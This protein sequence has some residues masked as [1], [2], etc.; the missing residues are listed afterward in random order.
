M[1]SRMHR[2]S[3]CSAHSMASGRFDLKSSFV[4]ASDP[5]Q[6]VDS[7][8]IVVEVD[9][10]DLDTLS[11]V[12]EVA[13]AEPGVAVEPA[14]AAAAAG[15]A[16]ATEPPGVLWLPGVLGAEKRKKARMKNSAFI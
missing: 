3:P 13:E 5:R 14:A 16:A 6:R 7:N 2:S 1:V 9:A 4:T 8:D 10:A 12:A 15:V 11:G